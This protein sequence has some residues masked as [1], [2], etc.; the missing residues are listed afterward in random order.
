MIS[1]VLWWLG[2][3]FE[4][5][6][7]VRAVQCSLIKKFPFFYLYLFS[8]LFC[9]LSLYC[10]YQLKPAVYT[11]LSRQTEVVNLILGYGIVLEIF[12]HVLSRY[13]G[14]ERFARI[15]GLVVFALILCFAILYP[16]MVP[17][18]PQP[19]AR[20]SLIERDF[21]TVQSIF[22]SGILGIIYYY[23]ITV[24]KNIR[25]MILGYGVWLGASVIMLGFSS[26][27]GNSFDAT[28]IFIQPFAYLSC[29]AVWLGALWSYSPIKGSN[30]GGDIDRDADYDSLVL[31]TRGAIGDMR[32]HLGKAGRL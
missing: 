14:A 13:P 23:G 17:G 15:A 32:A 11:P 6:I 30:S 26:Y 3:S 8:V 4:L 2:I 7:L 22:L 18:A 29:L 9:D 27:V 19:H 24:D 16:L 28:R 25:G 21:V 1:M 12:R 5:L 31:A 10:A 20:Y